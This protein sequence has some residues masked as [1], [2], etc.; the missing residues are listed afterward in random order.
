MDIN[1]EILT[2]LKQLADTDYARFTAKLVPTVTLDRF[3]GVRT[4]AL[5]HLARDYAAN[6]MAGAVTG[7]IHGYVRQGCATPVDELR[8]VI[9]HLL[10]GG[11][12]R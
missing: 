6:Y 5:R 10:G 8:A 2:R 7:V 12:F 11:I 3:I 4:P 9:E 1:S